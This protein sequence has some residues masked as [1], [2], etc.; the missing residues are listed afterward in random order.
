[1]SDWDPDKRLAAIHGS[2]WFFGGIQMMFNIG[3]VILIAGHR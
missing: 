1:M 3:L 2:I